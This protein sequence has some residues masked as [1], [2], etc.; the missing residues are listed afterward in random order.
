[1]TT[2]F[3]GH[4]LVAPNADL[5]ALWARANSAL[6]AGVQGI[7]DAAAAYALALAG[8]AA[9][10][11]PAGGRTVTSLS[12]YLLD[13]AVFNVKDF[14]AVGDGVTNDAA[15]IQAACTAAAAAH[16]TVVVPG[17]PSRTYR[18]DTGIIVQ[19][20]ASFLQDPE[21]LIVY[22]GSG[23]AI[24]LNGWTYGHARIR[25][26][27]NAINWHTGADTTSIGV[28]LISCEK[29]RIDLIHVAYFET[30]LD[31]RGDAAINEK[32]TLDCSVFI[33]QVLDN[34]RGIVFSKTGVG[35]FANQNTF[36]GGGVHVESFYSGV[37]GS[38]YLDLTAGAIN[39]N[40]FVGIDLENN[41]IEYALDV[42]TQ[43]SGNQFLNCRWE[44]CAKVR[45]QAGAYGNA[46]IGGY[47]NPGIFD[48]TLWINLTPGLNYLQ[49]GGGGFGNV[50]IETGGYGSSGGFQKTNGANYSPAQTF[51]PATDN[52]SLVAE[53]FDV[54]GQTALRI[55]PDG[56]FYGFAAAA[57][58][59]KSCWD[60]RNG[61]WYTGD[62]TIAPTIA[63]SVQSQTQLAVNKNI[64]FQQAGLSSDPNIVGV[65]V[66]NPDL[67]Q[68]LIW[69]TA[70]VGATNVTNFT[71]MLA[72]QVVLL[73]AGDAVTKL[74]H[75]AGGTG[76]LNL[77]GAA[78]YTM[79]Q[80]DALWF[81][82]I[83]GVMKETGR[84]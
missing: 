78:D 40:T 10:S 37:A 13:N 53:Y 68:G 8:S 19:P 25:L 74:K 75:L 47:S 32:G 7:N 62:G 2:E 61:A 38:K 44:S 33:G 81:V 30:G 70:N 83:G 11:A 42:G 27:R 69:T 41:F 59:A 63:L 50:A 18:I 54:A 76:Q 9:V 66:T 1:M 80:G 3:F 20:G 35:A 23:T 34:K 49:G 72:H 56:K 46:I 73:I 77:K 39:G 52:S 45:F 60:L 6:A 24:T 28:R 4:T 29:A 48:G 12:T 14:G 51:R 79:I 55:Q 16:G 22:H 64:N 43:G 71:N 15:A 67:S 84:V 82:N 21:S 58:W 57:T 5:D 65:G 36:Y 17:G 31:M 26:E